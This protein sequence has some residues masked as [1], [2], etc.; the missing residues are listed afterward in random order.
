MSTEQQ[1]QAHNIPQGRPD[2]L[3]RLIGGS[4][5]PDGIE[6]YPVPVDHPGKKPPESANDSSSI[7]EEWWL[8]L[9]PFLREWLLRNKDAHQHEA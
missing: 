4:G 5:E 1:P 9:P 7:S 6:D 8:L 2:D 3:D